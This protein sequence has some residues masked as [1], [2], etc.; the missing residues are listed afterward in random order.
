MVAG[1]KR[2]RVLPSSGFFK[3]SWVKPAPDVCQLKNKAAKT[4]RPEFRKFWAHADEVEKLPVMYYI[5]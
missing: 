1:L 3:T 2:G 5:L 4:P